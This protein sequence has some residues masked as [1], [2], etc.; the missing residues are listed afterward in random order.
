MSDL[1]DIY[2]KNEDNPNYTDIIETNNILDNIINKIYMILLTNKGDVISDYDFGA[3]I[4]KYLWSTTFPADII[5]EEI[6]KQFSEYIPELI[7]SKYNINVY[8]YQGKIQDVGVISI[9]LGADIVNV[10]FK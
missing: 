9:D 3:D 4:P 5:K 2:I 8:L 1:K 6:E 10:V 7:K